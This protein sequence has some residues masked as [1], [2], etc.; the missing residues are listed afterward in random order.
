M[1]IMNTDTNKATILEE[2]EI[3][4]ESLNQKKNKIQCGVCYDELTVTN[5]VSTPCNH[6]FCS[7]C[8]FKWLKESNTC[9]LCR[10][11]YTRYRK[12]DYEDI[13]MEAVTHEFNLFRDVINRT[14]NAL[15]EHYNKKEKLKK[16]I[17]DMNNYISVNNIHIT[18]KQESVRRM[19]GILEFKRGFY[20][21]C[22]FPITEMDLY[23]LINDDE[24]TEEWKNGFRSGFSKKFSSSILKNYDYL[25][26]PF[27]IQA[28]EKLNK[29]A[30][31]EHGISV[32]KYDKV[33][34][35]NHKL[36][37]CLS[38]HLT[39]DEFIQLFMKGVIINEDGTKRTLGMPYELFKSTVENTYLIS[40]E[41]YV[42]FVYDDK[43][44]T[45][46]KLPYY[47]NSGHEIC[48]FDYE[49]KLNKLVDV[50]K[51]DWRN[52]LRNRSNIYSNVNTV[53]NDMIDTVVSNIVKI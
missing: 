42:D 18:D 47:I 23:N 46:Y 35:S 51:F 38:K 1:N 12:W 36:T 32:E 19:T 17:K 8:F 49:V 14:K 20:K 52:N 30:K 11:K 40:N 3:V 16:E 53:V 15:S 24:E 22:H 44:E 48:Y 25:I 41:I 7:N 29:L 2:K 4:E 37:A 43:E 6:Q 33:K 34:N 5:A 45:L 26:D 27:I 10:N 9:P 21:A 50:D 39:K 31:K 28:R 13:N